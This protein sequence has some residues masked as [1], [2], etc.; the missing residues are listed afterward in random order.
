[1][2]TLVNRRLV[3]QPL[4]GAMPNNTQ[5]TDSGPG[6]EASSMESSHATIPR[7]IHAP[8]TVANW[9]APATEVGT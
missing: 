3:G 5:R 4:I 6:K 2:S 1:M 8:A 9:A 7:S